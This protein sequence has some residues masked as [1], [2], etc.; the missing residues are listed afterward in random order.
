RS[1]VVLRKA[2]GGAY[3]VMDSRHMGNDL[4]VAWPSAEI[5]VMG[6]KGAVEILHRRATPEERAAAEV[7]YEARLLNPYAAAERGSVDRVIDPA[8]TRAELSNALALLST[9]Q[10]RLVRRKHD[11]SPL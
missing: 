9:K 3:I 4:Y 8:D 10:E 2:Y 7:D 1:A 5:A 6:A 11:N